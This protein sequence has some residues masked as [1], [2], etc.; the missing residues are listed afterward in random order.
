MQNIEFKYKEISIKTVT[1]NST[2]ENMHENMQ[3][4]QRTLVKPLVC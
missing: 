2:Y 1:T 4:S 3:E